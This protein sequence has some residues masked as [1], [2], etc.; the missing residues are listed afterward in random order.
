MYI[1]A[2]V[3]VC[4]FVCMNECMYVYIYIYIYIYICSKNKVPGFWGAANEVPD[5]MLLS[6]RQ[7]VECGQAHLLKPILL[8]KAQ[9]PNPNP[10]PKPQTLP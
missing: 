1:R 2:C 4:M 6:P 7:A 5:V 8:P 9:T 10:N 3:Y